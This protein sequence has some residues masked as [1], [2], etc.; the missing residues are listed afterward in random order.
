MALNQPYIKFATKQIVV[1]ETSTKPFVGFENSSD[2]PDGWEYEIK[3][4]CSPFD[5]KLPSLPKMSDPSRQSIPDSYFRSG[6]GSAALSDL[7][8]KQF[9][10]KSE[11][12]IKYW[13]P[14]TENGFYYRYNIDYFF[15]GDN[16]RVQYVDPNDNRAGRNYIELDRTPNVTD[17][18]LAATF[19]RSLAEGNV[20][21]TRV[22]QR[23]KFT[24]TYQ[25]ETELETRSDVGKIYWS[26]VDFNKREFVVDNTIEGTTRLF[27]NKDYTKQYGVAVT[28]YA[29]L[30]AC[31]Q[32]GLST[33]A[34]YQIF[35]LDYFPV[36]ANSTFHLYVATS[37]TYEEWTRVDTWWELINT[38]TAYGIK[39]YFLDKDLG[40]VYFGS[41]ADG[42]IPTL[43]SHIVAAYTTT[44]RIEYE[45]LYKNTTVTGFDADVNPL[46]QSLNQGFICISHGD[47]E[48]A[49]ITLEINKNKISGTTEYG[50]ITIG[51]DYAILK[52]SVTGPGGLPV[53]GTEVGFTMTPTNIGYLDGETNSSSSTDAS[54]KAY[55]TFHPPVSAN[56]LGFYS[57]VVRN[58]THPSYSGYK[59]LILN[60]T[61]AGLEGK[62][63]DIYLYQILKDDPILGYESLDD[64][65]L[66][67]YFELSPAWVHDAEDYAKWKQEM[68][69]EYDL[70]EWDSASVPE[71]Q[72]ING[73]KVVVYQATLNPYVV[74]PVTGNYGAL[75]PVRPLL[76]EKVSQTGDAYYGKYR[77]IYPSAALPNCGPSS[78]YTVGGYWV[79]VSRNVEFQAQCWSSYYNKYI[80]SNTITARI[81]LPDYLLGVYVG[82]ETIPFGWRLLDDNNNEAAG[83]DGATFITI[84]PFSG[85]YNIV[86]IIND[87]GETDEWAS[88]PFRTLSFSF[89]IS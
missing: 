42:G 62:E 77:L 81:N 65:L 5:L 47:T 82:N 58:S 67:L 27:F 6:V 69:L 3:R 24:G 80:Y 20:Y 87:T 56:N 17:P 60:S 7:Y 41:A 25:N 10:Q 39:R 30:A 53:K 84:N 61:D 68:I 14:Y 48:A 85:P 35:F 51:A 34:A 59:E 78:T 72:A 49:G 23:Y 44:L 54:G 21:S 15:Y 29:D 12:E 1:R 52:A 40:I 16:S 70:V 9:L 89:T 75:M 74:N 86:D 28:K 33:G 2:L 38:A 18:I 88:A 8:V 76:V 73:R 11:N 83:L 31:D 32:L 37:S 4:W 71:G 63:D 22:H 55:S 13:Y 66:T 64:Y 57:T 45:E 43:G 36:L 79:V 26:N 46:N 50:P 19:R